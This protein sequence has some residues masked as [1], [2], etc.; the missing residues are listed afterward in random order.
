MS[1]TLAK[2]PDSVS[3]R[4]NKLR[5]GVLGA[6]D[7]I[8]S[9]A[10]T[11]IGVA[12]AT[13]SVP[14]I[15]AAG[16]AALSAGAFS[17]ATGEY[18]SVS[19]Q[20]DTEEAIVERVSRSS[21]GDPDG[22][23]DTLSTDLERRGVAPETARLAATDMIRHDAVGALSCIEGIDPDDLVNPWHAAW[24]SFFSFIA[25]AALPVAA[26]LLFPAAV[27]IPATFAMVLV[28]LA[29]TG[30]VSASLGEAQ[31]SRAVVRTIVGGAL[32]MA[33]TWGIGTLF[34]IRV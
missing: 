5:A 9:V 4:L 6:N 26:I 34:D 13:D 14:I 22:I 18:I 23:L 16:V 33:V 8:V 24:A 30:F 15:A 12:A 1:V 19:T 17:M 31:R 7:G 2:Q 32:A 20:R 27:R 21:N 25:G 28:A 3:A 29:L 11:V 10:A